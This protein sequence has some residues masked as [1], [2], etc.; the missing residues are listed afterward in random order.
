MHSGGVWVDG[1]SMKEKNTSR[2]DGLYVRAQHFRLLQDHYSWQS[3]FVT[4]IDVLDAQSLL[5]PAASLLHL[6]SCVFRALRS[7]PFRKP[8]T[9]ACH[10]SLQ[11]YSSTIF[12]T[13]SS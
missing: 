4:K 5:S 3:G 1:S 8:I 12:T 11:F 7:F 9:H 13:A 10:M 6:R 2:E